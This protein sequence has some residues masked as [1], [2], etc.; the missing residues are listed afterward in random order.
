MGTQQ[1]ESFREEAFSVVRGK[2][3]GE[4]GPRATAEDS[5]GSCTKIQIWLF[6]DLAIPHLPSPDTED[7][8]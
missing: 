2:E 1:E 5:I 3:R 7:L 6:S 4:G 8:L